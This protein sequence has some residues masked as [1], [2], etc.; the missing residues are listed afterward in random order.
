VNGIAIRRA[1]PEEAERLSAVARAAKAGWGYA[2]DLLAAWEG[3]LRV[4]A[5]YV[6]CER[7]HVAAR[8]GDLVGFYA[9]ERRGE[10]W[11][12]EHLWVDP[13]AQGIGVGRLLYEH[14]LS[15]ARGEGPGRVFI[16]ADPHAA[17][18][19]ARM[20][21]RETG[22]VPAPVPGDPARRLPLFEVSLS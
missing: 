1:R 3:T 20:G 10:H 8:G 5:E 21:A 2:A 18:F 9:L 7:V 15:C 22:S 17:G 16:E 19:Y 13:R 4:T 14:A 11:S 6:A 12:L